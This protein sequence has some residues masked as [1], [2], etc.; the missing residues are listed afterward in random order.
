M[1]TQNNVLGRVMM[2]KDSKVKRIAAEFAADSFREVRKLLDLFLLLF[3][4]LQ[5]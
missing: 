1:S 2:N 5:S 4:H 3:I